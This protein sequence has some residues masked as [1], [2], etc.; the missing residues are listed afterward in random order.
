MR[1]FCPYILLLFY[2]FCGLAQSNPS[3]DRYY[4][5][6]TISDPGSL[7]AKKKASDEMI[8]H[9]P[10]DTLETAIYSSFKV[11]E[12]EP[13][14]GTTRS[15]KLK[16]V[17]RVVTDKV[18]LLGRLLSKFPEKYS[19]IDQFYPNETPFYPNDYGTTSPVENLGAAHPLYDLDLINAPGA[20]GIT[21]GNPKVI[22][23]ISD[24]KIDSTHADLKGRVSNYLHY[25]TNA[26]GMQCAHGTNVAGISVGRMNNGEGRPG[27][28]SDCDVITNNYG[29]FKY[30][31]QL[32]AA[33]ARVINTSWARCNMGPYHENIEARI[34][35]LYEDG[36]LI[37][38]GAGNGKN[39]NKDDDYAPDD[40]AYPASYEKVISVTGVYTTYENAEDNTYIGKE[41]RPTAGF[42]K[43]RHSSEYGIKD[44]G[45]LHPKYRKWD[46]QFNKSI[47]I[48][49]PS[50]SYLMGN[51]WCEQ[52]DVYGGATSSA[53]PYITGVIGLIWSVNYCLDAYETESILKLTAAEIDGL[54]GNE[55][56]IG[57]LGAGRVD[58]YKAVKMARDMKELMGKVEI[59]GRDFTRFNFK[60][61]HAPYDIEISNQAFRDSSRVD[62]KARNSI[63]LKPGTR[64]APDRSGSTRLAIDPEISTAECFPKPLKTYPTVFNEGVKFL[65]NNED[66]TVTFGV[67]ASIDPDSVVISP[68]HPELT[69]LKGKRY[70]VSVLSPSKDRLLQKEFIFPDAGV[71]EI[72]FARFGY[73]LIEIV[74][75]GKKETYRIKRPI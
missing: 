47:D 16:N 39:C 14:F 42:L 43:D 38:A 17:Y 25:F 8:I 71:F 2:C 53:A 6:V 69:N 72:D 11:F 4:F 19:R 26:S 44:D 13:A 27:I 45:T 37:V 5:H 64:I 65:L 3:E 30:V 62:F 21:R 29:D 20:W 9:N 75:D 50:Q 68:L 60:L 49:A 1:T 56:Y 66:F 32:V 58:A 57:Q 12:F 7:I 35:E 48:C 36:I 41:G 18:E 22:I 23:G 73:L 33:G 51:D 46:M 24:S 28:C 70:N 59:K 34:N 10:S 31:E 40:Y 61:E 74:V 63:V 67:Y 55:Y 15:E 52:D 54:P